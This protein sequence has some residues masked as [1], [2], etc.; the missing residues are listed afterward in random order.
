MA[1]ARAA[2]GTLDHGPSGARTGRY[3]LTERRKREPRN[4]G[5]RGAGSRRRVDTEGCVYT[6]RQLTWKPLLSKGEP[7]DGR[8]R[9]GPGVRIRGELLLL[10]DGSDALLSSLV[11]IRALLP[12]MMLVAG[13]GRTVAAPAHPGSAG[14]IVTAVQPGSVRSMATK[15]TAVG[16]ARSV[17]EVRLTLMLGAS[18]RV[19]FPT[20]STLVAGADC[21]RFG[22]AKASAGAPTATMGSFFVPTKRR[23]SALPSR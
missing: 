6:H 5:R 12:L 8:V 1:L 19:K 23:T 22:A 16:G 11:A 9:V 17:C 18:V 2:H 21:Q 3:R 10:E 7:E 4:P 20:R 13:C 14:V 15:N